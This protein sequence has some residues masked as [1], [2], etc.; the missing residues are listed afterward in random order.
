MM[1]TNGS[2]TFWVA[3]YKTLTFWYPVQWQIHIDIN[4]GVEMLWFKW[5]LIRNIFIHKNIL[6]LVHKYLHASNND[7][8]M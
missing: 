8:G 4:H 5:I 7:W 1:V 3:G 6:S 2:L